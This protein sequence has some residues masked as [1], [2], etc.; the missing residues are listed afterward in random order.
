MQEREYH[1]AENFKHVLFKC[2]EIS[3]D[4]YKIII[5]ARDFRPEDLVVKTVG[6]TVQFEVDK[7]KDLL[8]IR[9][10]VCRMEGSKKQ[11]KLTVKITKSSKSLSLIKQLPLNYETRLT[12]DHWSW[13]YWRLKIRK[14]SKENNFL[15]KSDQI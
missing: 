8:L 4:T 1:V 9:K 15:P 14:K 3:D 12:K 2:F 13:S 6:Q 11:K 10:F 7:P 5:D